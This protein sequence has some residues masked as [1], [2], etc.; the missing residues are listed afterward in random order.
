MGNACQGP[1]L[2]KQLPKDNSHPRTAARIHCRGSVYDHYEKTETVLG[3]GFTGPVRL[4][5]GKLDGRPYAMKTLKKHPE[6]QEVI[7]LIRNEASLYLELDHPHIVRLMDVFEDND[8]VRLVMEYCSGQ[9]LYERLAKVETYSE[10]DAAAAT[11]EMLLPVEYL[12]AHNIVHRD[13]KLENFLYESDE[14]GAKLKLIDFGFS[15]LF[16][17]N[18]SSSVQAVVGTLYYLAPESVKSREF[19]IAV[20]MWA[21]GVI[22]YMLLAGTPPFYAKEKEETLNRICKGKYKMTGREWDSISA[23]AKDFVKRCLVVNPQKRMTAH[24]AMQHEFIQRAVRA[25]DEA[26]MLAGA[27]ASPASLLPPPPLSLAEGEPLPTT[28][29]SPPKTSTLGIVPLLPPSAPTCSTVPSLVSSTFS[30]TPSLSVCT[31]AAPSSPPPHSRIDSSILQAFRRFAKAN[32]VKRVALTVMAYSL[33]SGEI[34]ELAQSFFE[35]DKSGNGSISLHDF[36]AA[37]R[38]NFGLSEDESAELFLSLDDTCHSEIQYTEFVA[39]VMQTRLCMHEDMVRRAFSKFDERNTGFITAK[40][41]RKVMCLDK[42]HHHT[43]D[44]I[45]AEFDKNGDGK[46]DFEEFWTAM[47]DSFSEKD[48]IPLSLSRAMSEA[49]EKGA[50]RQRSVSFSLN[51]M[52]MFRPRR[53]S[54]LPEV[55]V[56]VLPETGGVGVGGEEGTGGTVGAQGGSP[57]RRAAGGSGGSEGV[58]PSTGGDQAAAGAGHVE[59]P[60]REKRRRKMKM[61]ER[62]SLVSAPL[63]NALTIL[64][65]HSLLSRQTSHHHRRRKD[66]DVGSCAERIDENEEVGGDMLMFPD[67]ELESVPPDTPLSLLVL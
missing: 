1:R 29:S 12:H 23:E 57:D 58:Q 52:R 2:L 42:H 16:H 26:A 56:G 7:E 14:P 30:Q 55:S 60:E 35:F 46:I 61:R 62:L 31:A 10:V 53:S 6:K 21:M 44:Q 11:R 33:T 64:R 13:L 40:Q 27:K 49:R 54:S 38:E 22:V 43:L 37:M 41:M 9:Q 47:Q 32:K 8:S 67:V 28:L 63:R 4:V 34:D 36:V 45:L 5:R 51:Q 66:S 50:K 65:S 3:T 59:C 39:A 19:S 25:R 17:P 24:E 15:R 48:A 18:L 20:D